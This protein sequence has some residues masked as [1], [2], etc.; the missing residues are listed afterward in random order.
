[1]SA[2]SG[3][4]NAFADKGKGKAQDISEDVSMGEGDSSEEESAD[5]VEVRSPS[6]CASKHSSVC[7]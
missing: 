6:Q 3:S 1:M 4:S 7:N 5:E 2:Q